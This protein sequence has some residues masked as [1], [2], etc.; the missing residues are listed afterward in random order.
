MA[1]LIYH[2]IASLD[3]YV[4]DAEGDFR[5]SEP[6][7]EVHAFI[8]REEGKVGTFLFGRRLYEVMVAWE[9]MDPGTAGDAD[10]MREFQEVW[11]AADKIVY[12]TTLPEVS[13]A[14][15][16][17]E[18]AFDPAAVRRL[19]DAATRPLSIGGPGLAAAALHAGLVDECGVFVNPIVVGGGTFWL[20]D[21][22]R[23]GLDLV[24]EYRFGN[25]VVFLRYRVRH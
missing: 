12:S 5:W 14:R 19:K 8:N 15:T 4:A 23:L 7:A 17:L 2:V 9:T 25:G 1:D 18:R 13:S 16:R 22:L 20:P 11:K 10:L 6:D 24:D 3:G 21:G